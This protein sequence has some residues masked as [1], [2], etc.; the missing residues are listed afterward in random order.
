MHLYS[1]LVK[2]C[3][4]VLI[5]RESSLSGPVPVTDKNRAKISD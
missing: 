4:G 2:Y 1:I 5:N 3:T